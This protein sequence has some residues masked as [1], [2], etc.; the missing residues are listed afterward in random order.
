MLSISAKSQELKNGILKF[1]NIEIKED[2]EIKIL[3]TQRDTYEFIM[4]GSTRMIAYP[5]NVSEIGG[6]IAKVLDI[7]KKKDKFE[8]KVKLVTQDGL[9]NVVN[10]VDG[11]WIIDVINAYQNKEFS[12]N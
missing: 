1:Q 5:A 3:K 10:S 8:I 9:K 6:L 4:S 7:K 12:L 2:Q 11:I